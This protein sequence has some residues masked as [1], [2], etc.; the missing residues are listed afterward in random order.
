MKLA[1]NFILKMG[2]EKLTMKLT[3]KFVPDDEHFT[4]G[5]DK[6]EVG[7]HDVKKWNL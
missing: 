7:V 6:R 4:W 1:Q 3:E 5:M 2:E